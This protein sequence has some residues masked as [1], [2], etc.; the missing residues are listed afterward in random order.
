MNKKFD[1]YWLF[2]ISGGWVVA[3]LDASVVDGAFAGGRVDFVCTKWGTK[4][5]L[6]EL[7]RVGPAQLK[8]SVVVPP[9]DQQ[10]ES[11]KKETLYVATKANNKAWGDFA[12]VRARDD[13]SIVNTSLRADAPTVGTVLQ[14]TYRGYLRIRWGY[15]GKLVEEDT[16]SL[17]I[18]QAFNGRNIPL[19][20]NETYED[21]LDRAMKN[22][23]RVWTDKKPLL[24]SHGKHQQ[25]LDLDKSGTIVIV[26]PKNVQD[27]KVFR[28]ENATEW[29]DWY[30]DVEELF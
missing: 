21:S 22:T 12:G 10:Q 29:N 18:T 3:S 28:P 13:S 4:L 6:G 1:G 11:Y 17:T 14:Q 23:P 9:T 2:V 30:R 7:A 5:G 8:E 24:H 26:K 16:Q 27:L 25:P 20:H 15:F 19:L